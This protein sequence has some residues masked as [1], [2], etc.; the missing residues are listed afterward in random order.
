MEEVK[1][2]RGERERNNEAQGIKVDVEF[3]ALVESEQENVP[4]MQPHIPADKLK[5]CVCIKKRPIF[6]QELA[7]GEIDVVSASNPKIIVHECKFKVDGI[8]KFV[9]NQDFAFDNTFS[10]D[11][12]NVDLYFYSLRPILDH[13]FNTG[14]ITVF[15]YGQTG[16]G[17]TFTMQG[18]QELAVKDLF[19]RGISYYQ[20]YQRN[21]TVTVAMYEI[22]GGKLYD[23]L[24]NHET[25]KVLEDKNQKINIQGLKEQ[26]VSSEDQILDLIAQGNKMRT[27]HATKANDTS[28]RSHA[29]CQIKI[30]EEDSK[31]S[32]KLLLVDL[33][34]S[35]RAADCQNNN[36]ER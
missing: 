7:N 2:Q 20:N 29:I 18:L 23:L 25:L 35:E 36:K 3:Q 21:F 4:F 1:R 30:Q 11:E 15:A 31:K 16:S 19:E 28:S 10:N 13:V 12:S 24:N 32:G 34:G 27:T 33:A 17:K 9:D 22:Y 5:I 14:I 6:N 26:F 8:T